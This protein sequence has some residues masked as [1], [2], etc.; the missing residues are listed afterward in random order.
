MRAILSDNQIDQRENSQGDQKQACCK[1]SQCPEPIAGGEHSQCQNA[2]VVRVPC[3]EAK[4]RQRDIGSTKNSFLGQFEIP[5]LCSDLHSSI[6]E[7]LW[8][9]VGIVTLNR[10]THLASQIVRFIEAALQALL[11]SRSDAFDALQG[12]EPASSEKEDL[13]WT[14]TGADRR[15]VL[16]ADSPAIEDFSAS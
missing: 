15:L 1:I 11:L 6:R 8:W 14:L 7:L 12:H 10:V 3:D 4:L 5:I 13:H 9:C 16:F 2:K